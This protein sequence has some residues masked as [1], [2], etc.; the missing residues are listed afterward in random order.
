M[1]NEELCSLAGSRKDR[2]LV[3]LVP[4]LE[5]EMLCTKIT[6]AGYKDDCYIELAGAFKDDSYCANVMN[7]SK[8]DLCEE[9]AT[10]PPPKNES[11]DD[12]EFDID[13]FMDMVDGSGDN[14]TN[15]TSMN[16]TNMSENESR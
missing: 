7:T 9:A 8:S 10:P 3:S 6:D 16:D 15:S 12:F 13:S 1:K 2:C 4:V 5:D 14:E 11:K